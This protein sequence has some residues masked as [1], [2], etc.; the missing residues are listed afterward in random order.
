MTVFTIQLVI[1]PICLNKTEPSF[2]FT[3]DAKLELTEL[4][5]KFLQKKN[6][7]KQAGI[8]FV[9]KRKLY[10]NKKLSPQ[11]SVKLLAKCSLMQCKQT[12]V[13][14]YPNVF[15]GA[16]IVRQLHRRF[17]FGKAKRVFL[18]LD[19]MSFFCVV[20]FRDVVCS[21]YRSISVLRY[22]FAFGQIFDSCGWHF[23][24][25]KF[26]VLGFFQPQVEGFQ[27]ETYTVK[28]V[29]AKLPAKAASILFRR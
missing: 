23:F 27:L 24:D 14:S 21:K 13:P 10:F 26:A 5:T 8:F 15:V 4:R 28:L 2:F 20:G 22:I 19:L 11:N 25:A 16:K 7:T 29:P 18:D 6:K 12:S 9:P 3:S 17:V 1:L